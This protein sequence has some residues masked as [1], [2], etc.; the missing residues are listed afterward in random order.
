M[1]LLSVWRTPCKEFKRGEEER[2]IRLKLGTALVARRPAAKR[3][4]GA[5][6]PVHEWC[7]AFLEFTPAAPPQRGK[8]VQYLPLCSRPCAAFHKATCVG[9]T[10]MSL[11]L[12]LFDSDDA[13]MFATHI[14]LSYRR[15]KR[16]NSRDLNLVCPTCVPLQLPRTFPGSEYSRLSSCA[17]ISNVSP[18]AEHQNLKS[19][20]TSGL[21]ACTMSSATFSFDPKDYGSMCV[22]LWS[23]AH[24]SHSSSD[25]AVEQQ[26][27]VCAAGYR[28][29]SGI[30]NKWRMACDVAQTMSNA[31]PFEAWRCAVDLACGALIVV[32]C[33]CSVR[34]P[35]LAHF[36]SSHCSGRCP[37][38]AVLASIPFRGSTRNHEGAVSSRCNIADCVAERVRCPMILRGGRL[39]GHRRTDACRHTRRVHSSRPELLAWRLPFIFNRY[40]TPRQ[41]PLYLPPFRLSQHSCE[42]CAF[43][44][45]TPVAAC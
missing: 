40:A 11:V 30:R 27:T 3:T 18:L 26:Q 21:E 9:A 25:H 39:Q 28:L 13:P 44:D 45:L 37:G 36:D 5:L 12:S 34:R 29:L 33:R 31:D 32:H 35:I 41:A 17:I 19:C 4:S 1:G 42:I 16:T 6:D 38:A 10:M 2:R 15:R 43:L 8:R 20:L 23:R 14:Q 22:V 7:C 24:P